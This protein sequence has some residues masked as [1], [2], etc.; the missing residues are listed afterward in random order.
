MHVNEFKTLL[1]LSMV[2][3]A[4]TIVGLFNLY[5]GNFHNSFVTIGGLLQSSTY[6]AYTHISDHTIFNEYLTSSIE[7]FSTLNLPALCMAPSA[8]L[9]MS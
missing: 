3:R 7:P 8:S 9:E 1:N 5:L 2:M 4:S 6:S